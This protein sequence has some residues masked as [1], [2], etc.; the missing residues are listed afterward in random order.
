MMK[1]LRTLRVRFA[2]WTAGLLLVSLLLFGIFVYFNMSRSL[3]AN[4]DGTLI[5]LGAQLIEEGGR[6]SF[7]PL[8][9]IAEEPQY[10]RLREQ[11]LS[12]RVYRLDGA[13]AQTFGPYERFLEPAAD[14]FN[15]ARS[16]QVDTLLLPDLPEPLRVYTTQIYA[17]NAPLAILQIA[18]TLTDVQGTLNLLRIS[19]LVGI[20]MIVVAAGIG[21]YFLAASALAPIDAMTR[22]A[23]DLSAPDLTASAL[24]SRLNLPVAADEVGRLAAMLDSML[25]RLEKAFHRERQFTADASHEL[26][27][28][29]A[30]M[31]MIIDSTV[32]QPRTSAEYVEALGDL[33]HEIEFMRSL[34][35]GLL[36]LARSDVAHQSLVMEPVQVSL[37]LK[38]VVE[39]MQ[40]MAEEKGLVLYDLVVADEMTLPG[41]SDALIRLFA[42]LLDNAIKYTEAGSITV[43]AQWVAENYR[44]TIR[45]TGLGIDA[46]H[47]SHLFERFYRVDRARS[48][49]GI[50]LG[51]AIAQSIAEAH[52]GTIA[53]ESEV[54][55]GSI[56]T[57][58]L[59]IASS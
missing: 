59:P 21:G 26:R 11:G 16:G 47:L 42:N 9:D 2:L 35:E 56:F 17:D 23:Q 4:V 27:T 46:A 45:D 31:Q 30:A 41:D 48:R 14:F 43:A 54:G 6:R 7:V 33:R 52:G 12:L 53:V 49:Q 39:S 24:S 37:L 28:P 44:I 55:V 29:L 50:G 25:A 15:T 34:T 57:V 18:Q 51:L 5:D 1:R 40:S 20:P 32:A 3:V 10:E 19:L 58:E 38:D 13:V 8:D 36:H 22:M